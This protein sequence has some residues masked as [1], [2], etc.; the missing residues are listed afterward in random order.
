ML[1]PDPGGL[2]E[3]TDSCIEAESLCQSGTSLA[4]FFL[5][6]ELPKEQTP[7]SASEALGSLASVRVQRWLVQAAD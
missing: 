4:C 1:I 3:A 6:R 7:V 5:L 2:W